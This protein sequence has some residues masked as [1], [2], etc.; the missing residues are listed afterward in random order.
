M[1]R[2]RLPLWCTRR[3]RG[4]IRLTSY[5]WTLQNM[6]SVIDHVWFT[7]F[8]NTFLWFA[9]WTRR[10]GHG[11]ESGAVCIGQKTQGAFVPDYS[12]LYTCH[13]QRHQCC[14]RLRTLGFYLMNDGTYR[15]F[16]TLWFPVP[17]TLSTQSRLLSHLCHTSI[18]TI[19]RR[20]EPHSLRCM[21][22]RWSRPSSTT[23][24]SAVRLVY[25]MLRLGF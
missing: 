21:V 5:L 1:K 12:W 14:K 19:R 17:T 11:R 3:C 10:C 8:C 20:Y 23:C 7:H 13:T 25:S 9:K 15:E 6:A 16:L 18:P 4:W 24:R 2:R 22:Q